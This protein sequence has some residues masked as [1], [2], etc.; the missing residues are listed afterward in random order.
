M[1]QEKKAWVHLIQKLVM[2]HAGIHIIIAAI[3]NVIE[4]LIH[5]FWSDFQPRLL[6][7]GRNRTCGFQALETIIRAVDALNVFV[8]RILFVCLFRQYQ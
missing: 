5:L 7:S 6:H 1:E 8:M 2:I 4:I 3:I